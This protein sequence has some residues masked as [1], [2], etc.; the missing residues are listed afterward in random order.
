[1]TEVTKQQLNQLEAVL[2][3]AFAKLGI[4]VEFTKHF[5]D[6]IND[7]RNQK[8]ITAKEI[9]LLYKK[10]Y[11]KYGK[12]LAKLPDGAQGVMKD[13]ESDINIPFVIKVDKKNNE[14]DLV[15]KTIM[16]KK[17]FT[18]PNKQYPVES[19][20][21]EGVN[22]PAIF[23][24]VF[25]AG[26][27]GSGKSFI[28][29]R[30][31]LTALGFKVVNSDDAFETGLKKAGLEMTPSNIYSPKGQEIRQRAKALTKSK[32][33]NYIDG[34]LG[35]V[36]DGTGKDYN[37]IQRQ[38]I[39]L[40]KLGYDVAMIFVN[41][42]EETA[43]KRNR[44][45][46]RSLPDDTVS[47]MWKDVQK[48]IGAF[49]TFFGN[50]FLIDNSES[51]DFEKQTQSVYKKI[52]QW[53]KKTP[54]NSAVTSWMKSQQMN[55]NFMDGRNPEDKGDSARHGIPKKATL[56]QLRK[57]RSSKTASPRKKQLAHWQINM[58][59]GRKKMSEEAPPATSVGNM[60]VDFAPTAYF[61]PK[62]VV[63]RR[64]KKKGETVLL[65]RFRQHQEQK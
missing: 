46:A 63:D 44:M 12:P 26:G 21:H 50:F 22:D 36:I 14:V 19:V 59:Q 37:K 38:A 42:D 18:T 49:Q 43:L 2:D 1:M 34:R 58:R 5:F 25:L 15:A 62:V 33:Q 4:D 54:K 10:E 7:A 20:I 39:E 24:A 23:K 32:L 64:H 27:P 52:Q 55:E 48:N 6:R 45:R 35:L 16:R 9:A 8:Q 40:R 51:S 41:T 31:A 13:L 56:A 53:S 60:S 3:K 47:K 61:K 57:I 29:G 65:K 11:I 17:N 28:V 30:T